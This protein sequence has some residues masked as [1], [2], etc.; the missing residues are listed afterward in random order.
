MLKNL[1]VISIGRLFLGITLLLSTPIPLSFATLP[2]DKHITI[3][4]IVE[5]PALDATRLGILDELKDHSIKIDFQSAQGNAALAAQIAQKFVGLAP[6]VMVG[7]GTTSTQALISANQR[8]LI[9]IVFSSVTDPKGAKLVQNF[10]S[11]EGIVTGVSNYSD[12]RM[13]FEIFKKIL[14]TLS[15][16]GIIYNPGEPNSV[17]LVEAMKKIANTQNLHLKFATANTTA[18]VVQATHSLLSH[19]EAIFINNDNTALSAFDAIV[20]ICTEQKIPVFCSDTAMIERGAL[21]AVGPNQYE[22][23]RQTGKIILQILAG[24][25]PH[26]IPIIFSTKNEIRLNFIQAAKLGLKLPEDLATPPLHE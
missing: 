2:S 23:G 9:P 25:S 22:I 6:Q 1:C 19:V 15:K 13:Q 16:I 7:I 3:I 18:D 26:H 24:E 20:K 21:A 14:P 4:Q 17:A 8:S 12:P 11:P 10:K 5:H